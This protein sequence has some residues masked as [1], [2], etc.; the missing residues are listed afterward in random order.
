MIELALDEATGLFVTDAMYVFA[1]KP[2]IDAKALMAV[3]QSKLFHFLYRATNTG[4]ARVIPQIKASKLL[5]LP[6]PNLTDCDQLI[7]LAERML[8]LNRQLRHASA[9]AGSV[10]QSEIA[11]T[12]AKIDRLVY[13][14]YGLSAR[15]VTIVERAATR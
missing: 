11:A 1:T 7:E 9:L 3:M 6:V 4:E 10:V 14:M 12:N 8:E 15:E 13:R 2:E 5:T